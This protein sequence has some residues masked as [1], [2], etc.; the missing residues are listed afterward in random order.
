MD[1]VQFADAATV[2]HIFNSEQGVRSQPDHGQDGDEAAPEK[3]G[4]PALPGSA[5]T[6]MRN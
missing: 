2:V 1:D 3:E 5:G 6:S 4:D